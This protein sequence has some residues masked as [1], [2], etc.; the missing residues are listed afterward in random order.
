MNDESRLLNVSSVSLVDFLFFF[1]CMQS[2]PVARAAVMS[3]LF[4]GLFSSARVM[5]RSGTSRL[6]KVGL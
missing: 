3:W 6:F 2:V 1:S 4:N 5:C